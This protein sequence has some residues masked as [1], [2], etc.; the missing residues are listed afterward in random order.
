MK[1]LLLALMSSATPI[2]L[3]AEDAVS[4]VCESGG[5]LASPATWGGA[6]PAESSHVGVK[7]GVY[8]LSKSL[9]VGSVSCL[10]ADVVFDLTDADASVTL[11][12][13][14][15][16]YGGFSSVFQYD[17]FDR[18]PVAV[19]RGGKWNC[20][21]LQLDFVA[22]GNRDYIGEGA[23]VV[24]TNGCEMVDVKNCNCA[25]RIYD[26]RVVVSDGSRLAVSGTLLLG[27]VGA[28]NSVLEVASGAAVSV[29]DTLRTDAKS[30]SPCVSANY[31]DVHG[32]GSQVTVADGRVDI[33]YDLCGNGLRVRDEATFSAEG[34][35]VVLG[36]E[37]FQEFAPSNN[38]IEVLN[39]ASLTARRLLC[40]GSFGRIVVSDAC[41][42]LADGLSLGT[43]A[44]DGHDNSIR[45]S[46]ERAS[47]SS[48][49][50]YSAD[51]FGNLGH[52]NAILLSDGAHWR[53]DG[54][55]RFMFCSNN[56]F[57]VAGSG[58]L[59]D[60]TYHIGTQT[61][62]YTFSIGN[63]DDDASQDACRDNV[64]E[65]LDGGE[66]R[67]DHFFV[68]GVGNRIVVSNGTLTAG[69]LL[70]ENG[71]QGFSIWMGRGSKASGQKIV[72][73]GRS[74]KIRAQYPLRARA[75]MLGGGTVL[76]Y[77]IPRDG[78]LPGHAVIEQKEIFPVSGCVGSKE[79]LEVSCVEWAKAEG[80]RAEC[81]LFRNP[82]GSLDEGTRQWFADQL[83]AEALP[84]N[85]KLVFR[86]SDV[87]LRRAS[88]FGMCYVVR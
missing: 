53:R 8:T 10:G 12:A 83:P 70:G 64:L 25:S 51:P 46:G 22:F 61:N 11:T 20:S 16:G 74:P 24:L 17:R 32:K 38:W 60:A 52:H 65:I 39:G 79:R 78:Y 55:S 57:R 56:L 43:T 76:R 80:P 35:D 13:A 14:C 82:R 71:D 36:R 62:N 87:V 47:L 73:R 63:Y 18:A 68:H 33:G 2:L 3:P 54:D 49:V 30:G 86:R 6:L 34:L 88:S 75:L 85:V 28:S 44:L 67:A 84:K 9:S 81:I 37:R 45:I 21:N 4:P 31:L 23:L 29:G 1:K 41:L 5:D 50:D 7:S 69:S 77:E 15:V 72:L 19:F 48:K 27:Y 40:K 66:F 58:T 42:S 26:G 59:F